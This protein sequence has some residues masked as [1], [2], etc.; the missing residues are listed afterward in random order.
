MVN[1]HSIT[2]IYIYNHGIC[3]KR[4]SPSPTSDLGP[5]TKALTFSSPAS[6]PG[7]QMMGI[8]APKMGIQQWDKIQ[9]DQD[10]TSITSTLYIYRQNIIYILW[11][12]CNL[13]SPQ[14]LP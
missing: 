2:I 9:L 10:I 3:Q 7:Q 6:A 5:S 12:Y 8:M 14:Q 11:L 13:P 1:N 4:V